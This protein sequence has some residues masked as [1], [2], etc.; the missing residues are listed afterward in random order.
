VDTGDST[1][2]GITE[3]IFFA[4]P[5]M[6]LEAIAALIPSGSGSS[7]TGTGGNG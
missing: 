1:Y 6:T 3:E 5:V 4:A 7:S 2:A